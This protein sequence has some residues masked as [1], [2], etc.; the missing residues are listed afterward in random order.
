VHKLTA[1]RERFPNQ[2][3][4]SVAERA[5]AEIFSLPLSPAHSDED[6]DDVV[7][8]LRRVHASLTG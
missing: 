5:G 4:L 6:I 7:A 3:P 2:V 8:A 1:Y